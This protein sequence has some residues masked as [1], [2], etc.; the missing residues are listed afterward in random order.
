MPLYEYQCE[1]CGERFEV[2]QKF[3]DAPVTLHEKCGGSVRR[4]LSVPA[5]QFKGSGFY[6]NDYAKSGSGSDANGESKK[7]SESGE[8]SKGKESKEGSGTKT[9]STASPAKSSDSSTSSSTS[10]S[11][12]DKK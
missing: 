10:S 1:S 5:L 8:S 9:E 12:S 3:A 4:L 6:I 7:K 2:M 11:V